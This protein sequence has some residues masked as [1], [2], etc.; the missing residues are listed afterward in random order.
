[1]D[2][3]SAFEPGILKTFQQF[4]GVRL[5][6]LIGA[7]IFL[8]VVAGLGIFSQVILLAIVELLDAS[9][10]LTYLSLPQ[11][12]GLIKRWYLPIA[13][14]WATLGPMIQMYLNILYINTED[15]QRST[16]FM[17]LLPVLVMFIPLV[18]IAWQ[19]SHRH[20]LVFCCLTFAADGLL[21]LLSFTIS[22]QSLISEIMSIAFIRTVLFLLVGNMI[23]DLMKVQR[24]QRLRLTEVNDH[25]IHYA[26]T[27]EELATS[28][29]R[30]RMARELHDVLAHT[31]SGIAVELEGVR[32]ML[33]INPEEAE[34]LLGHSL[35]AVRAGLTETRRALQSLRSS[36]LEDLGLGLAIRGLVDTLPGQAG[37]Q[38]EVHID[39]T[40]QGLPADVQHCFYRVAQEALNNV[41]AHAQANQVVLC[42]ERDGANLRLLVQDDGVG[43]DEGTVDLRD[44]YGLLGMRERAEMIHARLTVHSQ[45]ARGTQ[46]ELLYGD[47]R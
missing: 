35:R 43:F 4:I 24:E 34:E 29:E 12:P 31:M 25:L 30:N 11:L 42:L 19:Y 47:R 46:I 37:F 40:I 2:T 32:A 14:A 3:S 36:P 8:V 10:L 27:T 6:L 5:A 20:V 38:A 9:L 17:T 28:R 23:A 33:R 45:P 1:M 44:K 15:S 18:I 22:Q 21:A 39:E 16:L 7:F 41:V 26:A 13:V